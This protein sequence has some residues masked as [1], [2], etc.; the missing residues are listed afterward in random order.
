VLTKPAWRRGAVA[1]ARVGE[2]RS[3]GEEKAAHEAGPAIANLAAGASRAALAETGRGRRVCRRSAV[4]AIGAS[5]DPSIEKKDQAAPC[6]NI[7]IVSKTLSP[8]RCD[9]IA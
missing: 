1:A 3:G 9:S 8:L 5:D 6:D 2:N 4:R 7:A